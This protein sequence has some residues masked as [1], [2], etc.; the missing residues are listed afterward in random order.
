MPRR[1][2][3]LLTLIT[4]AA[5]FLRL[6]RLTE[7]PP[8]L[9]YDLAATALLGNEVAFNGYRPIFITA[10]T[11]HEALF[12]YWL[13]AWFRL[14]GS[15]IFTLR[16][17][18][19]TLGILAVPTAWFALRELWRLLDKDAAAPI[20]ALGAAF[21]ATAFFHVT[22]SRFG[23]RLFLPSSF[24][25]HPSSFVQRVVFTIKTSGYVSLALAG[26]F[27]ALAA[28]T[29]LAARLF[30]MPLALFWLALLFGAWRGRVRLR[31][32]CGGGAGRLRAAGRVLP[33]APR[34]LPEPCRP[35]RPAPR[36]DWAPALRPAP[37][38]RN[39]LPQRRALRPL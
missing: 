31:L 38:R 20:A 3:V 28:Y 18:A 29:Y 30:P 24:I 39:G 27:T 21:L 17:A 12:Y 36:R 15:S 4:L 14:A 33:P 1:Y 23:L 37:R 22:F 35:G 2:Y 16:L 9:H 6:W 8:G 7:V 25:H 34:R 13:A 26:A 19:A 10:Y 32:F 11:G 5:A